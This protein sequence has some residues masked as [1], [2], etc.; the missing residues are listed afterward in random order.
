MA[1]GAAG[2]ALPDEDLR[3]R[4]RLLVLLLVA[5][6]FGLLAYRW[7]KNCSNWPAM[8]TVEYWMMV[9]EGCCYEILETRDEHI[10]LAVQGD[11]D[12]WH[13]RVDRKFLTREVQEASYRRVV[14]D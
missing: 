14:Q 13:Y 9:H 10:C 1:G 5:L 8:D 7:K 12:R 3:M 11:H 2:R 6:C 4:Q